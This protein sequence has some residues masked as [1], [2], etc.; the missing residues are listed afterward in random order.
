M[1]YMSH[2]RDNPRPFMIQGAAACAVH[3]AR[4]TDG[5]R[6]PTFSGVAYTGAPMNPP[7]WFDQVV[8]DLAGIKIPSQQRPALRQHDH[9]QI[10]GHTTSIVATNEELRVSGVFSG[11]QQHVDTV[12]I[13]A[14]NGFPWQLSIGANP[15]RTEF[16]QAG[17]EAVVNGRKITGPATISRET[18][19]G[20]ISFVLGADDNTS[21]SVAAQW[22]GANDCGPRAGNLT[23]DGER[24]WQLAVDGAASVSSNWPRMA[25]SITARFAPRCAAS[26]IFGGSTLPM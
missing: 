3:A 5:K 14:S 23:D 24:F 19:I 16:L 1:S 17:E 4:D 8:I 11:E 2:S 6:L 18:E 20:E 9:E 22:R 7:G 21:V 13:P 26:A 15:I 25:P 12:F 10:V